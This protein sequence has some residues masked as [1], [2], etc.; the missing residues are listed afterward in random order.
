MAQEIKSL[1]ELQAFA[2][3]FLQE[4]NKTKKGEKATVIGLSGDLG[5]GKTAF[6]KCVAQILGITDVV[7]SPT[8]ILEKVYDIPKN[9]VLDAQFLKLVHIDAYRLENAKEMHALGWEA[10]L[11]DPQ[12]LI[13]IEWPEQVEGAL[14]KESTILHFEYI[15][16][17]IRQ[18]TKK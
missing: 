2:G 9:S 13:I 16:E 14:P 3:D 1:E 10:L 11:L 17:G 8:F 12:N 18:V 6:T 5:A 15:D 4:L 7:T